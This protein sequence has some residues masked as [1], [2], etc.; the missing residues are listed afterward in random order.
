MEDNFFRPSKE[1]DSYLYSI[2]LEYASIEE[3]DKDLLYTETHWHLVKHFD[4][5]CEEYTV[6]FDDGI[7][8]TKKYIKV[9]K[10]VVS[11]KITRYYSNDPNDPFNGAI[12]QP[13]L[14][15]Y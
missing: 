14:D 15:F 8:V 4:E 7:A 1:L 13:N 6:W 2:F 12:I 11:N 5:Q 9:N 3:L 10:K